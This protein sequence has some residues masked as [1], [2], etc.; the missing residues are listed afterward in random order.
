MKQSKLLLV[1]ILALLSLVAVVVLYQ[2][3]PS[4]W[5]IYSYVGILIAGIFFLVV[6]STYQRQSETLILHTAGLI[7]LVAIVTVVSYFGGG[8]WLGALGLLALIA[9]I[10]Y[11]ILDSRTRTISRLTWKAAFRFRFFWVMAILLQGW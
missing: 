7:G 3:Y 11:C 6:S 8:L 5:I 10:V 9:L 1:V 4:R 2:I